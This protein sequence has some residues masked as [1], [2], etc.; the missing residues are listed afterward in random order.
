MTEVVTSFAASQLNL[1]AHRQQGFSIERNPAVELGG[2]SAAQDTQAIGKKER[3]ATAN[4]ADEHA[5]KGRQQQERRQLQ[6]ESERAA[7][8]GP[9]KPRI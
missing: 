5:A 9:A 6:D 7:P 4:T 1:L 2:H 3:A 8:T